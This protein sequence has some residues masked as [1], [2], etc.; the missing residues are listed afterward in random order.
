M[1]HF[2]V[3]APGQAGASAPEK[4]TKGPPR[5]LYTT[6]RRARAGFSPASPM[7]QAILYTIFGGKSRWKTLFP[8]RTAGKL[9]FSQGQG[10]G[11]KLLERS[12]PHPSRTFKTYNIHCSERLHIIFS[13]N[14]PRECFR[15]VGALP[16]RKQGKRLR[17]AL[18]WP[19]VPLYGRK[20]SVGRGNFRYSSATPRSALSFPP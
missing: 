14:I 18:L 3:A 9:Q 16:Q 5:G 19:L 2:P 12:F 15:R 1:T 17:W 8:V 6:R 20:G 7:R 4:P 11:G 13:I 10:Y